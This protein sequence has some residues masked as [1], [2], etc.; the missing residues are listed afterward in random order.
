MFSALPWSRND[1]S[2]LVSQSTSKNY[3]NQR[4]FTKIA[5]I[6]IFDEKPEINFSKSHISNIWRAKRQQEKV[7]RLG[8][9][10]H[11]AIFREFVWLNF[12]N[13]HN[14]VPFLWYFASARAPTPACNFFLTTG[15]LPPT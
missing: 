9:R 11:T 1:G 12:L 15:N 7:L 10:V 13:S 4:Y 8:D 2:E 6:T 3:C 14:L 5:K